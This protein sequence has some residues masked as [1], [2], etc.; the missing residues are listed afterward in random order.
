MRCSLSISLAPPEKIEAQV[1]VTVKVQK[2][3]SPELQDNASAAFK[4]FSNIFSQEV[5]CGRTCGLSWLVVQSQETA[6]LGWGGDRDRGRG[7]GQ[8]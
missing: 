5:S 2:T 4:N 3:F 8:R 6:E 7:W 1:E